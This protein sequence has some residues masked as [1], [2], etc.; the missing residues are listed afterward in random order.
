MIASNEEPT[1]D[2]KAEAAIHNETW[3]WYPDDFRTRSFY[4]GDSRAGLAP[5]LAYKELGDSFQWMLYGDDDT[6]FFLEGVEDVVKDLD[7]NMPYVIT[8]SNFV[9]LSLS[10]GSGV[11]WG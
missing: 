7:P 5:W 10:R 6:V 9:I 8:G 3:T 4:S 2:L 1:E 11:G